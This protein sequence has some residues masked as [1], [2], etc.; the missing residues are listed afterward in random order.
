MSVLFFFIMRYK[1]SDPKSPHNDRFVLSKKLAF[2]DVATGWLGQGLGV[3]CGMAYTG[4]YFDQASY[5]V[6]CLLGDGEFSEGAVWEALAFASYY[7]LD[8]LLAIFSVHH[9]GHCGTLPLEHCIE[10]YQ[11]R[12]EAFGCNTY[13]VDGRDVQ[14]LCQVFRQAAQVKG[15]P[16]VV[17]AKTFKGRGM[18]NIEDA[19]SWYGKLMPKERLDAIIKLIQSQIHTTTN[20]VPPSPIEDCPQVYLQD[21]ELTSPP[22]YEVG[23]MVSTC[24]ACGL[25][26]AKLGHINNRVIVL[27]SNTK[28]STFSEIFKKEHSERFIECFVAEQNMVNVALGCAMRGRTIT[29]AS[30]FAAFLIRAYDQMRIGAISEVSI[31]LI[32]SHCGVC[33]G[34]DGPGQMALEDLA[35]FRALPNCTIFYPSDAVSTEHAV[36]L[37]ANTKGICY[38]RTSQPESQVIY[39]QLET[40]HVGQAKVIRHSIKDK[41]TV[42][43]AGVTVHEAIVA[44][45]DLARE[46]IPI[47]VID[48]FTIKP[49]DTATIISSAKATGGRIVTVEDHCCE[50]GIGEAVCA[51]IAMNPDIVVYQLAVTGVPQNR[52]HRELLDMVGIGARCIARAV[53]TIHPAASVVRAASRNT[54]AGGNASARSTGSPVWKYRVGLPRPLRN[55]PPPQAKTAMQ[56]GKARFAG[57]GSDSGGRERASWGGTSPEGRQRRGAPGAASQRLSAGAVG[58]GTYAGAK[59][60]GR[61]PSRGRRPHRKPPSQR[62]FGFS[63]VPPAELRGH[64]RATPPAPTDSTRPR[65]ATRRPGWEGRG[66]AAGL[67]RVSRQLPVAFL[68]QKAA[69]TPKYDPAAFEGA[70]EPPT[71][72]RAGREQGARTQAGRWESGEEPIARP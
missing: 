49:L 57:T 29:F 10:I 15:R 2:V 62:A 27:D 21:I 23:S 26:L 20:L 5:R 60:S 53:R 4:K 40:F 33:V 18:P 59:G 25:A 24:K 66:G 9:L 61:A 30:T 37:A 39:N 42:I 44:A 58:T 1:Q 32:G 41:I 45:A 47:R 48:L 65:P 70:E 71:Q 38:I 28:T 11:K 72:P 69:S 6:Y 13:V 56:Q 34:E 36:C 46:G 68:T 67:R 64:A 54:P 3:A 7:S 8:N 63:A 31:N 52:Q 19:E 50:G 14:A 51:A 22:A 12:C 17:I 55:P 35:I 43:G 16:T